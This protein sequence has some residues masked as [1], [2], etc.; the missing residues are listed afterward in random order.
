M[1][2]LKHKLAGLIISAAACL[3]C[4]CTNTCGDPN[5]V[6]PPEPPVEPPVPVVKYDLEK[7]QNG[8]VEYRLLLVDGTNKMHFFTVIDANGAVAMRF[9]PGNDENGWGTTIYPEAFSPGAVLRGTSIGLDSFLVQTDGIGMNISGKVS[10]GTDET[11]G[12]WNLEM[13]LS[14][15][16][17]GKKI[18]GTGRYQI[19]LSDVLTEDLNVYKIA[20]NYL[21]NVPL[22]D[23]TTG[24]TGDMQK[25]TAKGV[26]SLNFEWIPWQNPGFF[27]TDKSPSLDITVFGQHNIVDTARQGYAPIKPAYKPTVEVK[28]TSA[29][30][31]LTFGAFYDVA[32]GTEYFSDNIG[33][34]PLI[35]AG[36]T[37][38]TFFDFGMELS[39]N[40]IAGD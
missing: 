14:F 8:N 40:A 35:R 27:P 13:K 23:G 32:H 12:D 15:T 9:H 24:D 33:I 38:A 21:R 7:V 37:T 29:D 10:K 28:L 31:P 2:K 36:S 39:S 16:P 25:A 19:S 30:A 18:S 5:N 1:I 4:Q 26:G 20:S 34:T 6:F 22:L 17:S 11:A 3:G